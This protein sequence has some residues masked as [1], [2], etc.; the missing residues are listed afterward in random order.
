MDLQNDR[1]DRLGL[2]PAI[3]PYKNGWIAVSRRHKIYYE[4]CGT[5]D[6]VPVLI[7]HGGPGGGSRPVMRR[8]HDPAKYRIILF[9]QRGCGRSTPHAELQ[10]NTTWDLVQD[11]EKLRQHVGIKRWQ[12]FGGSWGS[13][14]SLIYAISY[15]E[16]VS[17]LILRGIFL[18]S[19]REILWFYQEGCNWLF[20]DYY[21]R[22]AE[23]IPVD[24]RYDMVAA[25]YRRLTCDDNEIR[26]RAAKA[27]SLWEAATL[28]LSSNLD[29]V[30]N[31]ASEHYALAFARIECHYFY[32]RGFLAEDN[33]IL[34][35]IATIQHLPC[36]IVHGRYDLVTPL[37]NAWLLN[38]AWPETDLRIVPDAGHAMSEPGNRH[39]LIAATRRHTLY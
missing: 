29:R 34:N 5:P 38:E 2:Y 37:R 31:F 22:F 36:T 18:L 14:L 27:W 20:P 16:R 12:L 4:E 39:E 30:R 19:R 15:P 28:S 6:G 1:P 21:A 24:E 11:M 9:D 7:V 8:Y 13:T 32:H 26:L 35:N 33:W 17:S 25:Y 23:I 3:P 10:E